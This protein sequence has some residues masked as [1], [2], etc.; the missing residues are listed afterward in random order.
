MANAKQKKGWEL[1]YQRGKTDRIFRIPATENP[2][3]PGS[4]GWQ[5]WLDGWNAKDAERTL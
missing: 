5:R 2:Y 4:V 3:K 1:A